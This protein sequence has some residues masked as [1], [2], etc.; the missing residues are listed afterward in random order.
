MQAKPSSRIVSQSSSAPLQI[1]AGGVQVPFEQSDWQTREPVDPQVVVQL[2]VI[3]RQ[4]AKPSSQTML[5]SSSMPLQVSPGGE[6]G[7]HAQLA[8]QVRDPVLP[9]VVGHEPTAPTAQVKPSSMVMSQS[10]S[11]PLHDS[12]GGVHEPQVHIALQTREPGVP[13]LL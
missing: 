4:Q 5:Q 6:Q 13:Q 7:L 2:E 10:S 1:S 3:P 11:T 12:T 8:P 9:Q